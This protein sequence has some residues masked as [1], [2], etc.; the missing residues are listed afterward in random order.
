MEF[1]MLL[2]DLLARITKQT[3]YRFEEEELTMLEGILTAVWDRLVQVLDFEGY[4]RYDFS[5]TTNLLNIMED[6]K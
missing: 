2:I 6:L 4:I 3:Y 5:T 1:Y